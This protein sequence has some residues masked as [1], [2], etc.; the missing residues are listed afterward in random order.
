MLCEFLVRILIKDKYLKIFANILVLCQRNCFDEI[1]IKNKDGK[2][3][4]KLIEKVAIYMH[5]LPSAQRT[6]RILQ[7]VERARQKVPLRSAAESKEDEE[8]LRKM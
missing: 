2:H 7:N 5:T 3:C 6:L 4:N 8:S 1:A